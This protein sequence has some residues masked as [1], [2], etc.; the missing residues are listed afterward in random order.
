M[1]HVEGVVSH[2]AGDRLD[3]MNSFLPE[4]ADTERN[5]WREKPGQEGSS[6]CPRW[7][8]PTRTLGA[9][10]DLDQLRRQAKERYAAFVAGEADAV[11]EVNAHYRDAARVKFALHNAQ[12]VLARSYGFDSRLK[13][14]AYVDGVTIKRLAEAVCAGD[15]AKVRAMLNAR[16]ELVRMDMAENDDR[17]A[18]HYAVVNRTPE[19]SRRLMRHGA[20]ARKGIYPTA[21]P[22]VR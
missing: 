12:L 3:S 6:S 2:F 8:P 11:A 7:I 22:P 19:L 9:H 18:L 5:G 1:S 14:K 20:D 10:P 21:M 16:P 4:R 15:L 13:L 17:R